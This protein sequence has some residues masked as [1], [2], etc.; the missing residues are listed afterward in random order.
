MGQQLLNLE[1]VPALAPKFANKI[2]K[3]CDGYA[4][5][6]TG[7]GVSVKVQSLLDK[8]G[9]L[10]TG[11]EECNLVEFERRVALHNQPT[12][13][14]RLASLRR[15]YELRLEKEFPVK[16]PAS[17]SEADIQAWLGTLPIGERLALLKSQKNFEKDSK[18]GSK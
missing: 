17:G 15:K 3:T 8:D 5:F 14:D 1:R 18:S 10:L 13:A 4:I 16:G 11:P 7:A 12:E 6:Y 2:G 9:D